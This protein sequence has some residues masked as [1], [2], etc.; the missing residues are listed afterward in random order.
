[1]RRISVVLIIV[2]FALTLSA[3]T[4][5]L[6]FKQDGEF[7][8]LNMSTDPL[9]SVDL[10]VSR[11]SV[12][13]SPASATINYTSITVAPDNSSESFVIIFGQIPA[14][15]LTGQNTQHLTL[16]FDVSQLDPSTSF[17]ESCSVDLIN[18]TVDCSLPPPTGGIHLDFQENGAQRTQILA[19][20]QVTTTGPVTIR[21]HQKSDNSTANVTGTVFGTAVT[22]ATATV[23]VNHSS[24]LEM[25]S[26]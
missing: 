7:A 18:F 10:S 20:E 17:V 4:Q 19:L 25:I 9:V 3:Q 6:K 23:G 11:N 22:G 24:T 12:S 13:G 16:D 14:S 8:T 1:M 26:N 21:T 2:F 5:H 15:A